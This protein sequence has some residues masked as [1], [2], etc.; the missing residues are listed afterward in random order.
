MVYTVCLLYS[1]LVTVAAVR[2]RVE[3][4]KA[5]F[6]LRADPRNC[7]WPAAE[8]FLGFKLLPCFH[9]LVSV[10]R[11]ACPLFRS[12]PTGPHSLELD[13]RYPLWRRNGILSSW[14]LGLGIL[15]AADLD[16]ASYQQMQL[17]A[18]T[19]PLHISLDADMRSIHLSSHTSGKS[20][21]MAYTR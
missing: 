19:L 1:I 17:H 8:L 10:G 12:L 2:C 16:R 20:R 7:G 4:T 6:S 11:D 9:V 5:L 21:N 18:A 3:S 13:N 15:R 14:A